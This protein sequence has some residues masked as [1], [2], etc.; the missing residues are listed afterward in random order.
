MNERQRFPSHVAIIMDGNGRWA[1]SRGLPRSAGHP[2]GVQAAVRAFRA[3]HE[4]N[5]E[6]L[7]L[8]A[9][10]YSNWNRPKDEVDMLMHL[11]GEFSE[12]H[13][14]ELVERGIRMQVIGDIDELPT[15]TR[16]RVEQT[17]EATADCERMMLSLALGY[18]SRNDL[19]AAVRAIAA[20]AQAGILLPEEIDENAIRRFLTTRSTPDPDLVIRTGGEK[21][22]SDFLLFESAMSELFFSDIMWPDFDEQVLDQAMAAFARRQRRFG[23]TPEQIAEG[24]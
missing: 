18:G 22:L 9:F 13:R 10:S 20:H 19:V 17:I 7:T 5:I 15:A 4:R 2:H 11:C 16:H 1:R 12:H 8:Y 23:R 14:A 21:R 6:H 24:A 3:C